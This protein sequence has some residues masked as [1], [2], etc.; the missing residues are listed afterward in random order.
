VTPSTAVVCVMQISSRFCRR[1]GSGLGKRPEFGWCA[2][3]PQAEIRG[4]GCGPVSLLCGR[5]G[6]VELEMVGGTENQARTRS[7]MR[8]CLGAG[9]VLLYRRSGV[10]AL[11]AMIALRAT[12][13]AS[14]AAQAGFSMTSLHH[15]RSVPCACRPLA[16]AYQHSAP[17]L[18]Q[19]DGIIARKR[20]G[21]T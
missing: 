2:R 7:T 19:H 16:A 10:R 11:G 1:Q 3:L 8:S 15:L 6:A 17:D 18:H 14:R 5:A 21:S 20:D 9:P 4:L 12:R 13:L